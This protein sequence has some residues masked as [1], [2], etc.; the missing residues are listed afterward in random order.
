VGEIGTVDDDQR[1][2]RV[3]RHEPG[4]VANAPHDKRQLP[5]DRRDTDDR[6]IVDRKQAGKPLRGHF[7]PADA[8]ETHAAAGAL[9]ERAHQGG[10][11]LVTGFLAGDQDNRPVA[12]GRLK[13]PLSLPFNHGATRS[14]RTPTMKIRSRSAACATRSGSA[15]MA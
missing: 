1:I 2:G 4:R 14:S 9:L 15:K 6:E 8:S 3:G 10:A 11:Q 7:A 12:I 13:G 5:R